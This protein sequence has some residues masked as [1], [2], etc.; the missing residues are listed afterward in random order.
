MSTTGNQPG[1]DIDTAQIEERRFPPPSDMAAAANA[2]PEIYERDFEE[3]WETEARQR[4]SW[5]R[6]F[7]SLFEWKPPYAA[8]YLGGTL[9]ACY[10]CVDRHVEAGLGEK[11]AYYWEGEPPGERRVLT[12]AGL[13]REVVRFASGLRQLGVAKGTPVGI[14]MGMVP[15][16]VV[17]MLETAPGWT[18]TVTS[19]CSAGSMT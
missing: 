19:G 18:P 15:E 3:F 2:G 1:R 11:V 13:Q 17:A 10:N 16:L 4:I 12:F 9:N 14:Y 8:W 6:D 7:G 5:F